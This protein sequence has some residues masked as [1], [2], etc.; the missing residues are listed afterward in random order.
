MDTTSNNKKKVLCVGWLVGWWGGRKFFLWPWATLKKLSPFPNPAHPPAR[1]RTH[2]FNAFKV[3]S[4]PLWIPEGLG[5][6]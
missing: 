5:P 2:P 3:Q 4:L 6:E 1:L